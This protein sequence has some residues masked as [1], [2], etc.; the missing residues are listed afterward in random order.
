MAFGPVNHRMGTHWKDWPADVLAT[1]RRG[2]VIPAHPLA[3][4]ANRKLNVR[5]Q[6]ALSRYYIDAGGNGPHDQ[7]YRIRL[8][9]FVP[10]P[11]SVARDHRDVV[12][13]S[14]TDG[15]SSWSPKVRTSATLV[16]SRRVPARARSFR[17]RN[18]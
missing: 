2:A 8:E 3:L 9:Q 7:A 16:V 4:D 6:R 14:S 11:S 18:K 17:L 15:G 1:L 5:R 10:D 12:L 13:V